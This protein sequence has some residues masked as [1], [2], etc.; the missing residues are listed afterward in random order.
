MHID[1]HSGAVTLPDG[2]VV[3]ATLTRDAFRQSETF[4]NARADH[5]GT[6]PWIHYQFNAG[7]LDGKELLVNLQFH[8][9]VL[10]SVSV[11]VDLY[12]PGPKDWSNYSLDVEA[13]T[14]DFHDRLLERQLGEPAEPPQVSSAHLTPAR[15]TLARPRNWAF[16]WGAAASVHDT[17]GGG[18]FIMVQYGNRREEADRIDRERRSRPA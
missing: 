18:T 3:T 16:A 13:A 8:D 9:Q 10:V 14:K 17:K 4:A 1:A 15:A 5:A 2:F 12:P 6:P 11:T 7:R